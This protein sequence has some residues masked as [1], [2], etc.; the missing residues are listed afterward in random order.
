MN[1]PL[2]YESTQ[3]I[4][5]HQQSLSNL[6]IRVAFLS[7]LRFTNVAIGYSIVTFLKNKFLAMTSG[8]L[9]DPILKNPLLVQMFSTVIFSIVIDKTLNYSSNYK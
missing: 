5:I 6:L 8:A 7:R 1:L 2:K 9:K 4:S 3:V